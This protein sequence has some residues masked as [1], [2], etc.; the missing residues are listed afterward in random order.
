[1]TAAQLACGETADEFRPDRGISGVNVRAVSGSWAPPAG[2]PARWAAPAAGW[3]PD[4]Q[5]RGALRWWDGTAW[6]GLPSWAAPAPAKPRRPGRV[7]VWL[8]SPAASPLLAVVAVLTAIGWVGG[9]VVLA[10]AAVAAHPVVPGVAVGVTPFL[11]FLADSATAG[12]AAVLL[13]GRAGSARPARAARATRRA[14]RQARRASPGAPAAVRI[15]RRVA[16][17]HRVFAS[18]PRPVAWFFAAASWSTAGAFAW[19]IFE[20]ASQPHELSWTT[21]VGQQTFALIWIGHLIVWLRMA[22]GQL[23]RTRAAARMMQVVSAGRR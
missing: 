10:A 23:D 6:V 19:V 21:A 17:R 22:C 14:A 16:R 5:A 13:A 1:V 11:L 8:A 20:A 4:P 18:L 9:A 15:V 3:Y 2:E 12:G 7:S